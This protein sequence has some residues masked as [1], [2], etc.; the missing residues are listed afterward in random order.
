[1][2]WAECAAP[3]GR[4]GNEHTIL[5]WKSPGKKQVVR[6]RGMREQSTKYYKYRFREC[7]QGLTGSR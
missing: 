3:M 2:R 7:G 6:S 4:M 5:A 1:M